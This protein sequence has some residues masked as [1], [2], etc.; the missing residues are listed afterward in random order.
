MAK[1]FGSIFQGL[2][3]EYCLNNSVLGYSKAFSEP[4]MWNE[5]CC[6]KFRFHILDN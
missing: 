5:F 3:G 6:I 2:S 4:N 1:E